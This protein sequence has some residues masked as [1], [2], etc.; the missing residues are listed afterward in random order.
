[1]I[2]RTT[3]IK[4]NAYGTRIYAIIRQGNRFAMFFNKNQQENTLKINYLRIKFICPVR[5]VSFF[6]LLFSKSM[7]IIEQESER[8]FV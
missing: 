4:K 2:Q 1:M 5:A 7:L 6:C 3:K 8:Q